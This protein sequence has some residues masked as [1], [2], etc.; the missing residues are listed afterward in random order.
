MR[1]ALTEEQRSFAAALDGLLAG[2]DVPAVSRAWAAGETDAG[3]AL[4]DR[5]SEIGVAALTVPEELGGLDGT[6]L[7]VAVA[8]ERLGFHGVPGPWLETVALAPALL[9]DTRHEKVLAEVAVGAARVTVAAPPQA[10]YALDPAVATHLYLASAD[11]GLSAARPGTTLTSVDPSRHLCRLE[12]EGAAEALAEGALDGALDR[13]ALAASAM[14]VGAAEQMLAQSV[15]YV[16]QRKQFG[17][18]IG[19]YQAVKHALAEVKVAVDFA[20]P[21]VHGAALALA[22]GGPE[23]ARDVSAAKVATSDAALLAGRT[24][25]QVHGA[26]GYTQEYNLSLWILRTRALAG[27]WGTASYHRARVLDH[28]TRS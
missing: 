6:P 14:L 27:A 21:L 20:R 7:D 10:P 19:E 5:L 16:G 25:L 2:A 22:D 9:A 28:L 24:A 4:W 1:F 13:A 11:G 17:R 3:L 8:F 18:V 15:A 26:I 12:T 23:A